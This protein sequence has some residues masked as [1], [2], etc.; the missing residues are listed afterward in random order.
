MK[1]GT[2]VVIVIVLM[3]LIV[4]SSVVFKKHPRKLKTNDYV[5]KWKRL[6]RFCSNRK[7]WPKALMAA[8]KLLDSALKKRR[9]GGKSMGERLV[10]AQHSLTNNDSIWFAHNLSKKA[11]DDSTRLKEVDVRNALVA[12]RQALQ[13][14]GALPNGRTKD[15]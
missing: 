11:I 3:V 10:S 13:D 8:D 5:Q 14:I 2:I 15:T 7:T 1:A 6:Q 9:F 4:V 12:Y